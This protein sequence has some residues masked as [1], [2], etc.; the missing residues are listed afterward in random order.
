MRERLRAETT[1]S[2]CAAVVGLISVA[3]ALTPE[4]RSRSD[5]VDGVLPPGVTSGARL[6]ALAFGLALIWLSA[7]LAR[8]RH[9]AWRLAVALV[10]GTAVAHLVKGLDAEEATASVLLLAALV[11]YRRRFDVPGDPTTARPLLATACALTAV[12]GFLSL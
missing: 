5:L 11:R 6:V 4:L 3:S 9:R 10:A 8:R 12:G 2:A 7:A 1:L